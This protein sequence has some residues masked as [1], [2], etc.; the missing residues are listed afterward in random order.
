MSNHSRESILIIRL[1]AIGDVVVTTPVT[2]ALRMAKPD[3]H[4]AWVVER[5][6]REVVTGNPY[7]DEV[8][9]WDRKKGGLKWR[10]LAE[11]RSQLRTRRWDWAIDCQGLLR[12]ALL[13]RLSG[14]RKVVG[15]SK[16]KEHAD[17]L[18]HIRVPRNQDDL[19]SRRRCLD[20]L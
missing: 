5:G 20:L 11:I 12:S 7:L 13:A 3:A 2:R 15:N 14:A 9:V 18:Y 1:S 16:A 6:A 8:I 4:I 10:D 19:S 17:W